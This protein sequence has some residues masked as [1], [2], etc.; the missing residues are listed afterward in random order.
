MLKALRSNRQISHA[1][2]THESGYA[3]RPFE[4]TLKDTLDWF[5]TG[6]TGRS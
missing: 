1:N 5:V 2:A 3:P 6:Q 4:L